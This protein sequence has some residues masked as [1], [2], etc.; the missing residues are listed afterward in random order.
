MLQQ[1]IC[2]VIASINIGFSVPAVCFEVDDVVSAE[3]EDGACS[4]DGEMRLR[5][6]T[7]ASQQR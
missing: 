5:R 4:L 7:T 2:D 3:P 1:T 6:N